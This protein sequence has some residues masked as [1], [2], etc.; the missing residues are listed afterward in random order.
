MGL[1]LFPIFI[2]LPF[3]ANKHKESPE[4]MN[5]LWWVSGIFG[6][7]WLYLFYTTLKGDKDPAEDQRRAAVT[8]LGTDLCVYC[9]G[10]VTAEPVP[11]CQACGVQIYSEPRKMPP[12]LPTP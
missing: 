2:A 12:P 7:I 9:S 6:A 4:D 5:T 11:H 1:F 8:P 10:P 3:F